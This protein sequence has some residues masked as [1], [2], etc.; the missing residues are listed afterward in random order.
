MNFRGAPETDNP[1][2]SARLNKEL[3][4]EGIRPL[5]ERL[6]IASLATYWRRLFGIS[7]QRF[8]R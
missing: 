7:T 5:Q 2:F 3:V 8:H 6:K 1:L 4:L